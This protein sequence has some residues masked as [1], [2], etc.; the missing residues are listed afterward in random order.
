M[1]LLLASRAIYLGIGHHSPE[2][3]DGAD[4]LLVVANSE[5]F[6][7]FRTELHFESPVQRVALENRPT[8]QAAGFVRCRG[9]KNVNRFDFTA[10]S[11]KRHPPSA[12][13]DFETPI[14]IGPL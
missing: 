7:K 9:W 2:V 10:R 3:L 13:A 6:V 11:D 8:S 4:C 1:G 14:V 5:G 12:F